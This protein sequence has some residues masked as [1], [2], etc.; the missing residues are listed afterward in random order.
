MINNT[1]ILEL[2]TFIV[3]VWVCVQYRR[4]FV[5][6]DICQY[7]RYYCTTP[8]EDSNHSYHYPHNQCNNRVS[9]K[10]KFL[11]TGNLGRVNLETYVYW[12]EID[13]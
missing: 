6:S 2:F 9:L 8:H 7:K 11:T 4:I 13:G 1:L 5:K 3:C 10:I 12:K